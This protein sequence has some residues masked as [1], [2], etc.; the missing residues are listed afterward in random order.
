MYSRWFVIL[1]FLPLLAA[2]SQPPPPTPRETTQDDKGKADSKQGEAANDQKGSDKISTAIDKLTS[3]VASWKKQSASTPQENDAPADWWSKWSTILLA[4]G[5]LAIAVLAFFQWR[6]MRGHKQSLEAMASHMESGLTETK[7][8]A[9]AAKESVESA[10]YSFI[11]SHRPKLSV[12]FITTVSDIGEAGQGISGDFLVFNTGG[13]TASLD[14]CYSEVLFGDSLP[15]RSDQYLIGHSEALS[16]IVL[17][18]GQSTLLR[19]PTAGPKTLEPD[20]LIAIHNRQRTANTNPASGANWAW[21]NL[22]LIGWIG[23]VDE[24]KR[25]R[26]AGFCRKYDFTSKRFAVC[27]DHDY[28]YED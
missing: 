5:T 15:M 17:H 13:T 2:Q 16:G 4:I 21:G 20:D 9:D 26:R 6:A 24:S 12:K 10:K 19:F 22:F 27:R 14:R 7:K 28:E 1:F 3:E 18:P 8:A 11:A 23:Y 25:T